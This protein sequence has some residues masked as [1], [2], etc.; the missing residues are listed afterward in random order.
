ME[1]EDYWVKRIRFFPYRHY[2]FMKA[3]AEV[4]LA[5]LLT[6][7]QGMLLSLSTYCERFGTHNYLFSIKC[8]RT[9]LWIYFDKI[10]FF[11]TSSWKSIS[12]ISG[13]VQLLGK[14]ILSLS[15]F[16]LLFNVKGQQD[17]QLNFIFTF[18]IWRCLGS[19]FQYMQLAPHF[20]TTR[21]KKAIKNFIHAIKKY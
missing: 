10:N 7:L 4:C 6:F 3:S 15:I 21:V 5:Y 20:S 2:T 14:D 16:P 18:N 13:F 17:I 1:Q 11:L 8:L 12:I 19:L 9:W